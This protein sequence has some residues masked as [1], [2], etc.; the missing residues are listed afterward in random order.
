MN[1]LVLNCSVL[2]VTEYDAPPRALSPNFEATPSAVYRV[3]GSDDVGAVIV[4][5]F[6]FAL[7][8]TPEGVKQRAER[9]YLLADADASLRCTV[10]PADGA[11]FTYPSDFA[12]GRSIRFTPGKG[13]RDSYLA[14][15]F[16]AL[17]RLRVD[18]AEVLTSASKQR[19]V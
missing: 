5:R 4:S 3:A 10:T 14:F 6:D 1:T 8:P 16:S 7:T 18:S 12:S 19:K 11:A 2:G 17:G 15:S 13:I 9:A